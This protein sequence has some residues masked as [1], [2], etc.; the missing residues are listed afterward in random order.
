[1]LSDTA[2]KRLKIVETCLFFC[3]CF[4]AASTMDI[5]HAPDEA[6]RYPI[7]QFI[8]TNKTLPN[9]MEDSLINQI[10]GF[11]Y[12]IYPYLT[13]IISAFFMR[14]V[15][16][17]AS[18]DTSLLIAARMTS[19]LAG[20]GTVIVVFRIGEQLFDNR[21]FSLLFGSLVCFLPQF[22]FICSY[23]NNDSF[24]V[25]CGT[26]IIYFWIRGLKT[27][28]SF[29]SVVG[30]GIG[31]GLCALSYYN[32]YIYLLASLFL[33][34]TDRIVKK[35][36]SVDIVGK[37]LIILLI[38]FAIAGW[39]FIRNYMLH[40]GDI[41]GFRTTTLSAE[42]YATEGYRPSELQTPQRMGWSVP[43][44]FLKTKWLPT[45]MVSFIGVF[46]YMSVFMPI[47][48]YVLYYIL[49]F[50]GFGCYVS[51]LFGRNMGRASIPF[52]VKLCF[53]G[54]MVLNIFL[55]MYSAYTNDY[56]AQGRYLMP[57]M[58]PLMLFV[59]EG[60]RTVSRRFTAKLADPEMDRVSRLAEQKKR[61]DVLC[62]ALISFYF[63]LCLISYFGYLIPGC[64]L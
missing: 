46:S 20:T 13:S 26:L 52:L 48:I 14:I 50:S 25:F 15:S 44:T 4:V 28:W 3:A 1:M 57:S 35:N 41:L 2:Y 5:S 27:G 29:G 21:A 7:A 10:W 56:Q 11:S 18:S 55:F 24:A 30:L 6:M 45:V 19:I 23:Q 54:M 62:V 59:A 37:A 49:L 34:F 12:A 39:F 47:F 17:F 43:F 40:N 32:A 61:D 38:A 60:F 36:S 31:C 9:G 8:F 53:F 58:V 33:Y 22:I 63:V 64:R 42:K 16:V 51:R